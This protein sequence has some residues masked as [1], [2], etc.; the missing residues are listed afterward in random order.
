[1]NDD[2]MTCSS[3]KRKRDLFE[4]SLDNPAESKSLKDDNDSCQDDLSNEYAS[5]SFE[6]S[7]QESLTEYIHI[8]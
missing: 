4:T 3:S 1:M 7:D 6:E 8:P 5:S 2:P